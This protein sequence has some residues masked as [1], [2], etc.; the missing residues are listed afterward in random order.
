MILTCPA[1]RRP[2]PIEGSN[3]TIDVD[4]VIPAIGEM[5]DVSSI[6]GSSGL[7][8]NK[9]GTV[10]VSSDLATTRQGVFAA[11]D[12]V[13]GPATVVTAVALGN[14]VAVAVDAFLRGH[15]IISPRFVSAYT[16]VPQIFNVEEYAAAKRAVM[17]E[18]PVEKPPAEFGG[19]RI[20]IRRGICP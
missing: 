4:I 20:R 7:S 13:L 10:T 3:F 16:E 19:S 8:V 15:E 5:P 9:D 17:P 14:K 11:G 6:E 12:V 2:V 18:L 1:R